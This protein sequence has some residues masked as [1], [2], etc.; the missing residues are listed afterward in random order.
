MASQQHEHDVVGAGRG[1]REGEGEG[2]NKGAIVGGNTKRGDKKAMTGTGTSVAVAC[3]SAK[4]AALDVD[5]G[6]YHITV[7]SDFGFVSPIA[8]LAVATVLVIIA[9]LCKETALVWP[10]TIALLDAALSRLS[11]VSPPAGTAAAKTKRLDG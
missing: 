7:E 9:L 1:R 5:A 2:V 10:A 8:A 6:R 4:E 11:G 3:Q